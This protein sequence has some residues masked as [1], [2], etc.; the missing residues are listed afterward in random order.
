MWSTCN[1]I[2]PRLRR[3]EGKTPDWFR[4]KSSEDCKT[5]WPLPQV[6]KR[7]LWKK[8]DSRNIRFFVCKLRYFRIRS[9]FHRWFFFQF[10]I[11]SVCSFCM[12]VVIV[13]VTLW[14]ALCTLRHLC[15]K[16]VPPK[17][18]VKFM[19]AQIARVQTFY[20]FQR[21][22]LLDL[23]FCHSLI[24]GKVNSDTR[25]SSDTRN[26]QVSSNTKLNPMETGAYVMMQTTHEGAKPN[27]RLAWNRLA[28]WGQEGQ[29]NT[30]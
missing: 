3:N 10:L 5:D 23:G 30:R 19:K 13:F 6:N 18:V 4:T 29:K 8:V 12:I 25:A 17:S 16:K 22:H 7:L 1:W 21:N 9:H 24:F 11:F 28:H 26:H 14:P 15:N 20:S 2:R 27:C